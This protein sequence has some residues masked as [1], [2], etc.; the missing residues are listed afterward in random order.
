MDG[1]VILNNIFQV[2]DA[3]LDGLGLAYIP[4]ISRDRTC[5]RGNSSGYL[6]TGVRL[7]AD[8]IFIIL[9]AVSLPQLSRC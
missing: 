4:R 5:R 8:T 3:A 6:R 2:R 7:G 9:A 1:Q